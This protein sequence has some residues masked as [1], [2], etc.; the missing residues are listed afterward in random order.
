VPDQEL[1]A[2][3]AADG[4]NSDAIRLF[5][6]RLRPF[7][8]DAEILRRSALATSSTISCSQRPSPG[9]LVLAT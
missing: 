5:G 3:L 2:A 7:E 9:G 6:D 1:H 4:R 8:H